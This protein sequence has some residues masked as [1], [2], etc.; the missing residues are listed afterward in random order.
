[1]GLHFLCT[2]L[3]KEPVK[4][5]LA[6]FCKAPECFDAVDVDRFPRKVFG[7]ADAEIFAVAKPA[8]RCWC[9]CNE[10]SPLLATS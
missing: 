10:N 4:L 7:F 2:D 5:C 9:S 8:L 3:Y 6:A 1:M